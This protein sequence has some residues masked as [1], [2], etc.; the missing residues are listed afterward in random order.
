VV[1]AI[2]IG[3]F[4][5]GRNTEVCAGEIRDRI[6]QLNDEIQ[7]A[8]Q[9]GMPLG[10]PDLTDLQKRLGQLLEFYDEVKRVTG[11]HFDEATIVPE[12]LFED[13]MRD[14]AHENGE[15][16][17]DLA[18]YVDWEKFAAAARQDYAVL[19]FGNDTVLVR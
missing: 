12:D 1:T 4:L 7:Q 5:T 8:Q 15:V 11:N 17:A 16:S 14:W 9:D 3:D 6:N 2:D 10:D 19:S 18:G 13:H